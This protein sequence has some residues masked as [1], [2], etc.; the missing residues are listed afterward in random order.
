MVQTEW[1]THMLAHMAKCLKIAIASFRFVGFKSHL[2]CTETIRKI[3]ENKSIALCIWVQCKQILLQMW[4]CESSLNH[5]PLDMTYFSI[6]FWKSQRN[7]HPLFPF[8]WFILTDFS[9]ICVYWCCLSVHTQLPGG[10]DSALLILPCTIF[11]PSYLSPTTT[12]RLFDWFLVH[13]A[14]S[15]SPTPTIC[16]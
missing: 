11:S 3:R 5:V 14:K 1:V 12:Q 6:T 15:Q 13:K 8:T 7:R 4:Y 9:P 2:L 10:W 16:V